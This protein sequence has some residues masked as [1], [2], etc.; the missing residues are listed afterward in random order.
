DI[1]RWCFD[2]DIRCIYASSAATY[3]D[4]QQ[5]YSDNH[6]LFEQLEPLNLY[7]KSKLA[8]DIWARDGKYLDKVVGLRFFNVFGPNEWHKEGMRS[9][10]CKK[11][12]ELHE[13]KPMTLFKSDHPDYED[14][15][16]MRDFIYVKDVI[17]ATLFF[18]DS[19]T[20][21]VFNVGTGKARTWVDVAKAMFVALDKEPNVQFID[22][23]DNLRGQ[24]QNFTQADIQK[25]RDAGFTHT[26]IALEETVADYVRNYL[27]PHKHLGE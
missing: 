9:V 12:P 24:Y 11:F 18:M 23:P 22:M 2:R 6:E 7:G 3:G 15:G 5:G 4:G 13:G 10:I 19:S 16:Q 14:G 26:F 21:G 17:A 27:I 25:I 20:G 8:V 1:I